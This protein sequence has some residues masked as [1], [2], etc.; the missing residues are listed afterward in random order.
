MPIANATFNAKYWVAEG[1]EGY[2][3]YEGTLTNFYNLIFFFSVFFFEKKLLQPSDPSYP[4]HPSHP[5]HP[6]V[7]TATNFMAPDARPDI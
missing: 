2:E 7:S 1:C 4:S 3:G 6:S 5:S